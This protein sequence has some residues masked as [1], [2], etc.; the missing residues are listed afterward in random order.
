[1]MIGERIGRILNLLERIRRYERVIT[2]DNLEPA[3]V[4]DMKGNAKDFCDQAKAEINQ[5]K[6][7]ID[8]WS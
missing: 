5:I 1:M 4:D 3:T 2:A 6:S 7:E 8:E